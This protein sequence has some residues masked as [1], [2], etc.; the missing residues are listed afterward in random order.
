MPETGAPQ[1]CP[2]NS[3]GK[4]HRPSSKTL[5]RALGPVSP[6]FLAFLQVELGARMHATNPLISIHAEGLA[7]ML[8]SVLLMLHVAP[9][10]GCLQWDPAQRMLPSEAAAHPWLRRA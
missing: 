10:Q 7:L 5:Q 6:A 4:V 3:R 8:A 2:P 1:P 9:M